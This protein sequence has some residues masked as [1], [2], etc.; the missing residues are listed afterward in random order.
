MF[1]SYLDLGRYRFY[2]QRKSYPPE[3]WQRAYT[4]IR[5]LA[6]GGPVTRAMVWLE[7]LLP[8]IH[9]VGKD[10][11]DQWSNV[12]GNWGINWPAGLPFCM[13]KWAGVG[14]SRCKGKENAASLNPERIARLI[15]HKMVTVTSFSRNRLWDF[16]EDVMRDKQGKSTVNIFISTEIL[17]KPISL[18]YFSYVFLSLSV[19][20]F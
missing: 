16:G 3:E 5:A 20:S 19:I 6:G 18:S 14:A 11:E 15:L 10:Q 17:H 7:L 4:V 12:W 8:L 1:T 2:P 13:L 9:G